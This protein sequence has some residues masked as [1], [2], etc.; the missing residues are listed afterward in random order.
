VTY[1]HGFS[2]TDPEF[3]GLRSICIESAA[4]A[5]APNASGGPEVL[6][7]ISLES[8]GYAPAVFLTQSEKDT[9]RSFMRGLVR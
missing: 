8:A 5:Y 9:L 1:T 3:E 2:E 6:S 4:R 7:S